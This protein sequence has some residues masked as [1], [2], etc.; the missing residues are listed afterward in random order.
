MRAAREGN[1]SRAAANLTQDSALL[2]ITPTTMAQLESLHP[3]GPSLLSQ[4]TSFAADY[5]SF[6]AAEVRKALYSF[7]KFS[8]PGPS[9]LRAT[10]I[11]EALCCG[12]EA[13]AEDLM[14]NLI[15][16]CEMAANGSFP[17]SYN[18]FLGSA[19]LLP[20]SKKSGGVRPIAV[21][22]V[23]RRLVSKLL[24]AKFQSHL[25]NYLK[26][27]QLGCG[28]PGATE[29]IYR[30]IQFHMYSNAKDPVLCQFDFKNAFNN[31]DRNV[32]LKQV[33]EKA[34]GL[35]RWVYFTYGSAP[36]LIVDEEHTVWSRQG[37]QPFGTSPVLPCSAASCRTHQCHRWG[38]MVWMVHGRLQ[39][40]SA[41][42]DPEGSL[43]YFDEG[44]PIFWVG[45]QCF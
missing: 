29:L 42:V 18:Q 6:T 12:S 3:N 2:P 32:L 43:Q 20:F 36:P 1:I 4:P 37:L 15:C 19:R 24:V 23:L 34:P 21:G 22:E 17:E 38:P 28:I 26:P 31:L 40:H 13:A 30:C 44:W 45:G 11:Q 41:T 8:A 16:F 10:H 25:V 5:I 27:L 35:L 9:G 33:E 7:P 39:H 14:S